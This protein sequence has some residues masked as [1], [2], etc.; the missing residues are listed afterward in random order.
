MPMKRTNREAGV[1][2]I[3]V[4][5]GVFVLTAMALALSTLVRSST[6]ELRARKEQM[7]A[8]YVARGA[9]YKAITTMIA[10]PAPNTPNAFIPGQRRLTWK[11]DGAQ[12][13]VEVMDES[14]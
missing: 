2:L 7:Q 11:E 5:W 10:T 13:T 3:A 14:G 4:M 1:V 8:Y 6:E 12:V 9:V